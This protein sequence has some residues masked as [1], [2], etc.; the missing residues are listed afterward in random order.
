M[1]KHPLAVLS[2][3]LFVMIITGF[4]AGR[5]SA[6]LSTIIDSLAAYISGNELTYE[7]E[8][9]IFLLSEIRLPR[10]LA[11]VLVGAALSSSGTVYQS[12]FLNPLVSPGILGVL[13]GASFGAAM[14]I[15][16]VESWVATQLLA[17]IFA[18]VAVAVALLLSKIFPR[19]G[20]LV[21]VLGGMIS[22]SLF[23]S[24]TTLLKYTA[25]TTSQLSEIIY[26]LMGTFSR[27]SISGMWHVG[28][29]IFTGVIILMFCGKVVNALS[30]GDEEAMSVGVRV[31]RVRFLLIS[32]T[33]FICAST[34]VIAGTVQWVGLV[35]P[36][37][38][39]F[40]IGPDNRILLP[41]S[42]LGGGLFML[43]TDTLVRTVFPREVPIGI[44]T[45]L[46]G[47][48]LF[49]FAVYQSKGV[50]K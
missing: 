13:A 25:D 35:I 16:V 2:I 44:V 1:K 17:F 48:P 15:V 3:F 18:I 22:S 28:I 20:M 24:L 26:W 6:D 19:T 8:E 4:L 47:L 27:A 9:V 43:V 46:I 49:V 38:L 29:I 32:I 36:H 5:Y 11:A 7:Q 23:N 12:V 33:T 45:S 42:A 21:L 30:M 50:W 41:A 37:I 40:F 39:R 34:V 10:I 31:K 14:G